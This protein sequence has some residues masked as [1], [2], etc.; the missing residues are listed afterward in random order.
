VHYN[1]FDDQVPSLVFDNP[2]RATDALSVTVGTGTA[3]TGVGGPA[4]GRMVNPPDNS[5]YLGA[6]GTTLKLRNH[7][8]I[9][10]DVNTGRVSQNDQFFPYLTNTAVVTPVLA[11]DTSS[12]PTQS[13]NGKMRTTAIVMAITS[14]P[15]ELLHLALR[16][17]RYDL[18][19]QTPRI[20]FPGTASWDRTFSSSPRITVPYGYT[21]GR[22]D[23]SADFDVAPALTLEGAF[24]RVTV[25]RTFRETEQTAEDT[26][27]VAAIM[28]MG[29]MANLRA[30]YEKGN[31]G[32][33]GLDLA[34][35]EDASFP[36]EQTGLPSN[37]LARD[38][39]LRFDQAKRDSDR[40]GII[41]D[42]SAGSMTT[43]AFTYLHNKDTYKETAHGLQNASY[44]TYTGEITLSPGEQWNVSTYYSHEK[45]GMAQ[46]QNGT[47]G[48]PTLDDFT[49]SL[50]D[51]ADTAGFT[52]LA[53]IV[54]GKATLNLGGRYQNLKGTAGFTT[55]P[56]STY[57]LARASL[58]GVQDI[59]NADNVRI[60]RLEA[61]VDYTVSPQ[62]TLSLGTWHEDYRFSDVDT[63]GLQNL[64]PGA[65]FLAL[66]D[67]GYHATVGYVRLKYGW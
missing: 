41:F 55:Q 16:Y 39:N 65:F 9:T 62:V 60:I 29:G 58:G 32:Y 26:G 15:T 53:Q 25:D 51:V 20:T 38:G 4:S 27:S 42:M 1:W 21:N 5:A 14:K 36:T 17:R 11:A 22:V 3:A 66:D 2:F 48:F 59:P 47:S 37:L 49:I 6:V 33:S 24:R 61:S 23:A 30:M 12:L 18:D 43:V 8:R 19:N 45:N 56:G 64:Y 35:S 13:L 31:R 54:P 57:Q 67:G 44:D 7:T 46:I 34:R 52:G 63:V 28:H 50:R 40:G 10:V